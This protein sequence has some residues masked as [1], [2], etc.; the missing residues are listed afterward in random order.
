MGAGF[1]NVWT[2]IFGILAAIANQAAN[3]GT[4][5]PETWSEVLYTLLSIALAVF[6][7]MAKDATTG[8]RPK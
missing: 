1:K 6:G 8:S 3:V 2:T 7:V 5:A 4:K